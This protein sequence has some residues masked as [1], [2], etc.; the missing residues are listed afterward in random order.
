MLHTPISF[1]RESCSLPD[2]SGG[3]GRGKKKKGELRGSRSYRQYHF[4]HVPDLRVIK[5]SI[6]FAKVCT[7]TFKIPWHISSDN[8]DSTGRIEGD[9]WIE[10]WVTLEVG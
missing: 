9:T 5:T 4:F 6:A 2:V 3:R 10:K 1:M 7:K 8:Q